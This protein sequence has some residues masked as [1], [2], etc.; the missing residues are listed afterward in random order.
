[1]SKAIQFSPSFFCRLRFPYSF[2][3]LA[4]QQRQLFVHVLALVA[5]GAIS[6][7]KIPGRKLLIKCQ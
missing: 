2:V 7:T 5:L 6:E 1:L 3:L 4:K